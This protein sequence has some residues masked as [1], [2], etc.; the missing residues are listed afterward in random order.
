MK[1]KTFYQPYIHFLLNRHGEVFCVFHD[2]YTN[3]YYY[4]SEPNAKYL[5]GTFQRDFT[6]EHNIE[7]IDEF[8]F[9]KYRNYNTIHLITRQF[10]DIKYWEVE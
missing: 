4:I 5:L 7:E 9:D 2:E 8:T 3:R 1:L 10:D 6:I